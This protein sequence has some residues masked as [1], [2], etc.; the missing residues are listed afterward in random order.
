LPQTNPFV[1]EES[2]F[3][4]IDKVVTPPVKHGFVPG[5]LAFFPLTQI[6]LSKVELHL[7]CTNEAGALFYGLFNN[8]LWIFG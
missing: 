1:S 5:V 3:L 7:S 6:D 8:R 2:F 4:P